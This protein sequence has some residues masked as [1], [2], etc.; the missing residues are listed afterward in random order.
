MTEF[1]E[2]KWNVAIAFFLDVVWK[3]E[4]DE[5]FWL[6]RTDPLSTELQAMQG[7]EKKYCLCTFWYCLYH[8]LCLYS[9]LAQSWGD[10]DVSPW[11]D[12]Q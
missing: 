4:D 11:D 5:M 12:Y 10:G 9:M 6:A 1:L 8:W 7:R 2:K 3:I